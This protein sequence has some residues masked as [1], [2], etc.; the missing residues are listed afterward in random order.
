MPSMNRRELLVAGSG[1]LAALAG[2]SA[3][4]ESEPLNQVEVQNFSQQFRRFRITVSND[5]DSALYD[6]TFSLE[7][8]MIEE[9]T[10]PFAGTPARITITVDGGEPIETDWPS[11]ITEIRNGSQ[12]RHVGGSCGS[13]GGETVTGV[14]VYV[15]GPDLVSLRPT[16]GT[17]G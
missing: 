4:A 5:Q 1:A 17:V 9:D 10:E 16:C 3:F 13:T 11:R 8:R 2:C 7:A 12:V 6:E 15:S 14:F